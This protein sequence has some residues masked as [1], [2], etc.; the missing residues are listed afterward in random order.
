M[1]AYYRF[2]TSIWYRAAGD[3]NHL[4]VTR[5]QLLCIDIYIYVCI[6]ILEWQLN[7]VFIAQQNITPYVDNVH[8][9][10]LYPRVTCA[11]VNNNSIRTKREEIC[12]DLAGF[13]PNIYISVICPSYPDKQTQQDITILLVLSLCLRISIA[14]TERQGDGNEQHFSVWR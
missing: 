14:V 8:H 10:S 2:S 12:R 1:F 11:Y 6:Y 3:E 13:V 7:V 5:Q 4:V 9:P